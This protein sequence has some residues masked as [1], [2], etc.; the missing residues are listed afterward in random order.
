MFLLVATPAEILD[1]IGIKCKQWLIK[2]VFLMVPV[3][4]TLMLRVA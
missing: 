4:A 1:I 3:D 2:D